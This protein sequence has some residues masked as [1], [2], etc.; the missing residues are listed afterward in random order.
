LSDSTFR[1]DAAWESARETAALTE[2]NGADGPTVADLTRG[3][4]VS[5]IPPN[6][7]KLSCMICLIGLQHEAVL[8][9]V[10]I[11]DSLIGG[12]GQASCELEAEAPLDILH[13]YLQYSVHQDVDF[14]KGEGHNPT[15]STYQDQKTWI[16]RRLLWRPYI[17]GHM[18]PSRLAT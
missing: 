11:V 17:L 9:S 6:M 12:S 5:A 18:Q 1:A 16:G 4:P 8:Q 13:V 15:A 14:Q 2:L 3:N 7:K 10:K